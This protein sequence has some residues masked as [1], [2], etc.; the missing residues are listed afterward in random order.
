MKFLNTTMCLM[1]IFFDFF[2]MNRF[3]TLSRNEGVKFSET[4]KQIHQ[5]GVYVVVL[6]PN[7][8]LVKQSQ[9]NNFIKI[10]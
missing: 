7:L 4:D 1:L 9:G 5:P 10:L 2:N 3:Y 6:F 8:F